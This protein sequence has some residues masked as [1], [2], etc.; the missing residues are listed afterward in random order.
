MK[1]WHKAVVCGTAMALLGGVGVAWAADGGSHAQPAPKHPTV[2]AHF[3]GDGTTESRFT[4]ITPCRIVD[5]RSHGGPIAAN[6]TRSYYAQAPSATIAA[7]GGNSAGCAIP[8]AATAVQATITT[9]GASGTGF[10]KTWPFNAGVPGATFLNYGKAP[11][12]NGGTVAICITCTK[13]FWVGVYGHPTN[14]V[15]DVQG[16][17]LKPMWA[18][19]NADGSVARGSRVTGHVFFGAGLY[20]VDF[21]RDVTACNLVA[22]VGSTTAG[23]AA[24]YATV[25]GRDGVP[26]GVFVETFNPAG[27]LAA[28]P[29]HLSVT[30]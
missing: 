29:F 17:Y 3:I 12:S 8:V 20:E 23:A 18:V 13:D 25:A 4:P 27:A 16:Y 19:V 1:R 22:D 30:C 6:T 21:D 5:T 28:L 15:V 26:N 10:L 2:G 11:I 7:Q 9:V 24:G 14:V